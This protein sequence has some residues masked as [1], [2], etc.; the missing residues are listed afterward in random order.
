MKKTAAILVVILLINTIMNI[1]VYARNIIFCDIDFEDATSP[2]GGI[3]CY[4]K[5]NIIT[6]EGT[7]ENH[8]A[9]IKKTNENDCHMDYTIGIHTDTLIA[10]ADFTFNAVSS[11]MNP[12]YFIG[13]SSDGKTRYD[14]NVLY[15]RPDMG[16]YFLE[17][18]VYRKVY[19]M[20]N[21]RM[22][23][24]A[25]AVKTN[26]RIVELYVDGAKISQSTITQ[27][28]FQT[29]TAVRNWIWNDAGNTA[30]TI[31]NYRI[32]ESAVPLE[33][34]P[35]V[36]ESVF[37]DDGK[38]WISA[39]E[40]RAIF[41]S[42]EQDYPRLFAQ[43][44][45]FNRIKMSSDKVYWYK[46]IQSF[47]DALLTE[48]VLQYELIDGYRLLQVSREALKRMQAWGFMY[49]MT[50]ND[51]YYTRAMADLD[52]I[53]A[54][55]DWH[56]E[57]FLDT[58]E[59]MTAAAVGYDWFYERMT[60]SQRGKL[61]EQII[62]KGLEPTRL[63]YY[64]RLNTGGIAGP[65]MNFV[66][67]SNNMNIVDNCGAIVA[68][69]AVFEQNPKL[70]SD[71]IEKAVRSLD[72]SLSAF[73][74]DG[75]WEE[76]I[77]YWIYSMEYLTRAI[78]ALDITFGS[79]F[80]LSEYEGLDTAAAWAVS[81]DAYNGVNSYHDTWDGMRL[82]TFA[83]AGLGKIYG[84]DEVL[85]YRE[86]TI[87]QMDYMP[88]VYDVLWCNS[89]ENNAE[90]ANEN[91]TQKVESVSIRDRFF[92]AD[93]SINKTGLFF[94]THG[95]MNNA[96]HS[97]LDAGA[98]VFDLAGERWAMDIPPEDY[99]AM[100]AKDGYEYYRK[101]AEGHNTVV[102]NP[103]ASGGQITNA[104][105]WVCDHFFTEKDAYAVYDMSQIYSDAV[106]A[107]KRGFYVGD[108]RRSLT[109]RDEIT[110]KGQADVYWFMHT[111]AEIEPTENGA[112]LTL[113][114][115]RLRLE[116]HANCDF[117]LT[118]MAAE[119]LPTSPNPPNQTPNA[120][121]NK[122][123][124]KLIGS[125]DVKLE[126]K[127][128]LDDELVSDMMDT[129]MSNWR[130][131]A[132]NNS[133]W[134][135][136]DFESYTAGLPDGFSEI[137]KDDISTTAPGDNAFGVPGRSLWVAQRGTA[138]RGDHEWYQLRAAVK[139]SEK[140]YQYIHFEQAYDNPFCDRWLALRF[141]DKNETSIPLFSFS[142]TAE[143]ML[144]LFK[145][146]NASYGMQPVLF[147]WNSYD[148]VVDLEKKC[149]D[150]Y[151][152]GIQMAEH[153]SLRL[154][155]DIELTALYELQFGLNHQWDSGQNV[156]ASVS[157]Y[158]DNIIVKPLDDKPAFEKGDLRYFCTGIACVPEY[159]D[160]V[161]FCP[162]NGTA[163]IAV[164][165]QDGR[166]NSVAHADAGEL[167]AAISDKMRIRIFNWKDLNAMEPL[168]DVFE[169]TTAY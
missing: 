137:C 166:L 160:Q 113:N 71:V 54:F 56:P 43:E 16:L 30:F 65:S 101:R 165:N 110:L 159:A 117:E 57:H 86:K 157:T 112:V 59:M 169:F 154:E 158:M 74:P 41:L 118:K 14:L 121:I 90:F 120:G 94:S 107:Y 122:V 115:K 46:K 63:A 128:A 100:Y 40:I 44:A 109:V 7:A 68:A 28:Q 136:Y 89:Q 155:Q 162:K 92:T 152:N 37:P 48:P 98:F 75:A 18:G 26:E 50:G 133:A 132:K 22:Y 148:I 153:V 161:I 64:G 103:S 60:T 79:D 147:S 141:N 5:E 2:F 8:Y 156:F 114:G 13:A 99:N 82:D 19:T 93:G 47:A 23:H 55:S 124:I 52:A 21:D 144:P 85:N 84:A 88:V 164:Y 126:V 91:Y 146:D 49:Q 67:A 106:S 10:E 138:A 149:Y 127:L 73:A 111:K 150:M 72:Y 76:G 129:A 139:P 143:D 95:G 35:D 4:N 32:Y 1:P 83:L 51:K 17:Q 39:E 27:E 130:S 104:S 145:V 11:E 9:V 62:K 25:V 66:M 3:V 34:L 70:C 53:C 119:P 163:I 151:V 24:I 87:D 61:A 105:S 167:S 140:R 38:S 80:G 81:L 33:T 20:E 78:C 134:T 77:N 15:V 29:V 45:D 96:Y 102:I 31:D 116:A 125:G 168:A 108:D 36:W 97:H 42:E 131:I 123:A 69:T 142:R 12:F 135:I 6:I 58:A